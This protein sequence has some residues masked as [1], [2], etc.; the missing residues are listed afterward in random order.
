MA[1]TGTMHPQLFALDFSVRR[2][3]VSF[4]ILFDCKL[5]PHLYSLFLS[6]AVEHKLMEAPSC[7]VYKLPDQPT[8]LCAKLAFDM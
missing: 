3:K 7:R 4:G 8:C 2:R 1:S 6:Q 5:V